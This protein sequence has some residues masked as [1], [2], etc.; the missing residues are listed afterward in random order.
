MLDMH[1][2]SHVSALY[3][4]IRNKALTQVSSDCMY[5]HVVTLGMVRAGHGRGGLERHG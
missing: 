5:V 3:K 4:L 1:L 2:A